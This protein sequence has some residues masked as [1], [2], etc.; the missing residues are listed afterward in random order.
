MKET[1]TRKEVVDLLEKIV[2]DITHNEI[3]YPVDVSKI[4]KETYNSDAYQ[5]YT[6]G[7]LDACAVVRKYQKVYSEIW[8]P[9]CGDGIMAIKEIID[10]GKWLGRRTLGG[11]YDWQE[12]NI[13][14]DHIKAK[15]EKEHEGLQ[16]ALEQANKR[17]SDLEAVLREVD[18]CACYW[19]E[20]Y[21]P[22]GLPERIKT[23]L[24]KPE[25]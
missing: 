12:H 1:F 11:E 3:E 17:I 2:H 18:D 19:S 20:Y 7:E 6:R 8:P 23:A 9:K 25:N 4:D 16:S 21:V 15:L 10:A 22:I 24:K 13:C 14:L 5:Y